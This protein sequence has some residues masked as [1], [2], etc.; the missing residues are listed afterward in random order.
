M[1]RKG[2]ASVPKERVSFSVRIAVCM[3]VSVN[4]T[5]LLNVWFPLHEVLPNF[6]LILRAPGP[7]VRFVFGLVANHISTVVVKH[8][9]CIGDDTPLHVRSVRCIVRTISCRFTFHIWFGLIFCWN[10]LHAT[11]RLKLRMDLR[12]WKS[13]KTRTPAKSVEMFGSRAV[14]NVRLLCV[15][16][17]CV[18]FFFL[19]HFIF[20]SFLL[21]IWCC[22]HCVRPYGTTA[23]MEN[24]WQAPETVWA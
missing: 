7:S 8:C 6:R 17:D 16:P 13:C 5:F 23:Q 12:E 21:I 22:C 4:W 19:F 11:K 24:C 20:R 18:P 10:P 2:V 15:L 1:I 3:C 14:Q 9:R